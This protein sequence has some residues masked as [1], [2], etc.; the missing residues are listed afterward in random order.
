M[1]LRRDP[2][3]ERLIEDE[4]HKQADQGATGN[5]GAAEPDGAEEG[6]DEGS[7]LNE[8][9]VVLEADKSSVWS[10]G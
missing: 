5:D 9:G 8:V 4:G 10:G 2:A 7:V 1:T 6:G 3:P